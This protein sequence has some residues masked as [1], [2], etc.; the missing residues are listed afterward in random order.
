MGGDDEDERRDYASPPCFLHELDPSFA[1]IADAA[2]E[3]DVARWRKAERERL[4]ARRQAVPVAARTGADAEIAAELDRRLGLLA[5]RTVALYWPFRG[6]PDLRRWAAATRA[7]GA[8]TCLP[9]V[10]RKA[11][12][13]VFRLW[14][15]EET[16]ERGVWNIPIPPDTS[17]EVV[18]DIVIAPV[19]GFDAA[20]YR[21]GYGG[22]FYDRTLAR[23]RAAGRGPRTIGVG[24]SFQKLPTIFPQPYDIA[25]DESILVEI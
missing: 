18:P 4:I 23:L 10:V 5:G 21:L 1:G 8:R 14:T 25:L 16:L 15:G 13:L 24:F 22:G 7:A 19:V 2:T 12:P 9:V 17:P 20:N 11:A 3:R 6:E